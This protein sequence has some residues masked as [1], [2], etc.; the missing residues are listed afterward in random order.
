LVN[1]NISKLEITRLADI[2]YIMEQILTV[3]ENTRVHIFVQ[4]RIRTQITEP[5][6]YIVV[7]YQPKTYALIETNQMDELRGV[8]SKIGITITGIAAGDMTEYPHI[9]AKSIL[10]FFLM[11]TVDTDKLD[12][13]ANDDD[14]E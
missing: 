3:T 13:E 9:K 12:A 5:Q 14:D 10:E 2:R 11:D 4:R 7:V 6:H 8:L 1:N